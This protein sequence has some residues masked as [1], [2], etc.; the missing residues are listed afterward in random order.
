MLEADGSAYDEYATWYYD[1]ILKFKDVEVKESS[2][3]RYAKAFVG[4][5]DVGLFD[6]RKNKGYIGE[7]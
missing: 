1:L 6:F 4:T 7:V 5:N 2:K 3:K